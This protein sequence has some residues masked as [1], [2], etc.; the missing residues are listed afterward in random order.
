MRVEGF[1]RLTGIAELIIGLFMVY[2]ALVPGLE[3]ACSV[4][5]C[6]VGPSGAIYAGVGSLLVISGVAQIA[7]SFYI[8]HGRSPTKKL[9]ANLS[10]GT[11]KIAIPA[12]SAEPQV[13]LAAAPTLG[14]WSLRQGTHCHEKA[15]EGH[16]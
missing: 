12:K 16:E 1:L 11:R 2:Y 7:A 4:W 10:V 5:G 15:A 9:A 14:L 8:G 3:P 6:F 13:A